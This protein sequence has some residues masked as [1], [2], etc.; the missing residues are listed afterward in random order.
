MH[1]FSNSDEDLRCPISILTNQ[2]MS[3]CHVALFLSHEL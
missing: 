3:N 2:Q 1:H